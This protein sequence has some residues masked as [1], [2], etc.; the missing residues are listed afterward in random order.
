MPEPADEGKCLV[1]EV[2]GYQAGCGGVEK[3]PVTV[4]SILKKSGKKRLGL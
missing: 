2:L 4:S 3:F 1:R